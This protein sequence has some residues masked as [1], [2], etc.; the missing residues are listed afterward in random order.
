M[1]DKRGE[2]KGVLDKMVD[3]GK[4]NKASQTSCNKNQ[5]VARFGEK[6]KRGGKNCKAGEK[7]TKRNPIKYF[8]QQSNHCARIL[9]GPTSDHCA[10]EW[11]EV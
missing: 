10:S 9:I 4:S 8:C 3:K 6:G 11:R 7:G 1:L 5:Q 2:K